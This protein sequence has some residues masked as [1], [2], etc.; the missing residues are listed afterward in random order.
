MEHHPHHRYMAP[1]QA[2]ESRNSFPV[3]DR[4]T[5]RQAQLDDQ[6][7]RLWLAWSGQRHGAGMLRPFIDRH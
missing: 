1:R 7:H 2:P 4:F 5:D 6:E 3:I